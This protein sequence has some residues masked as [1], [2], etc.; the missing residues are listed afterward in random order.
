MNAPATQNHTDYH[1]YLAAGRQLRSAA[2]REFL[3]QVFDMPHQLLTTI[4]RRAD[5]SASA[6]ATAFSTAGC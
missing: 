4:T 3:A 5:R 6:N 1:A 2:M